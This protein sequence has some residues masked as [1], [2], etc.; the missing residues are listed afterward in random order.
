MVDRT[1]DPLMSDA[2]VILTL[3]LTAIGI[4][5]AVL[6]GVQVVM[7]QTLISEGLIRPHNRGGGGS[8]N[9]PNDW[10]SL[11]ETLDG[12]YAKIQEQDA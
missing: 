4:V 8:D 12:I 6:K 2:S 11:P 10:H 9:W 5:G 1:L 3:I 7:R